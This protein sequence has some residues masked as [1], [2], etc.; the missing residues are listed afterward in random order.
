M[1]YHLGYRETIPD[2]TAVEK[3]T[4]FTLN[5]GGSQSTLQDIKVTE[6]SGGYSFKDQSKYYTRNRFI[7]WRIYHDVLELVE[8]SLDVNLIGNRIRY[9]FANTTVLDGVTIHEVFNSV[10]VLV[11]TASSVHRLSFP[12]PDTIHNQ[13][14]LFPRLG[15]EYSAKSIFAEATSND[16][17]NPASFYVINNTTAVADMPLPCTSATGFSSSQQQFFFALSYN[18]GIILLVKLDAITGSS[19][20]VE[21]KQHGDALIMPRFISRAFRG[22]NNKEEVTVS[23]IFQ[24]IASETYLFCLCQD[25][26]VR[27]WS[28]SR[29]HCSIVTDFSRDGN[30]GTQDHMI[31]KAE[32]PDSNNFLIATLLS[33]ST[34]STIQLLK[35]C[36]ENGSFTLKLALS[37]YTP[38]DEDVIDFAVTYSED[39]WA[40]FR[41]PHGETSVSQYKNGEWVSCILENPLDAMEIPIDDEVEAKQNYIDFI[42]HPG[43]FPVTVINK[44]LSIYRKSNIITDTGL[45]IHV[46]KERVCAVIDAQVN[47]ELEDRDFSEEGVVEIVNNCWQKFYSCCV[48]YYESGTRPIGLLLLAHQIPQRN[49]RFNVTDMDLDQEN[50]T[51]SNE[52]TESS[53]VDHI[54]ITTSG[55][56]IIKKLYVSLIRPTD[57]LEAVALNPSL[58]QEDLESEVEMLGGAT[59]KNLFK[60]IK[61]LIYLDDNLPYSMKLNFDKNLRNLKSPIT[62][63]GEF[64]GSG[65]GMGE[66]DTLSNLDIIYNVALNVDKIQDVEGLMTTLLDLLDIGQPDLP[67]GYDK[68]EKTKWLIHLGHLYGSHFATSFITNSLQQIVSVRYELCRCLLI[69]Q[70]LLTHGT[71]EQFIDLHKPVGHLGKGISERTSMLTQCYFIL[72]WIFQ[73]PVHKPQ[74]LDSI[75]DDNSFII[76]QERNSTTSDL[77]LASQSAALY[78]HFL[79]ACVSFSKVKVSFYFQLRNIFTYKSTPGCLADGVIPI[80]T[81]V[82]KFLLGCSL[83]DTGEHYK[84]FDVFN[85][86]GHGVGV[87]NFIK[88]KV[89]QM[90]EPLSRERLTVLYYLKIIKLFEQHNLYDLVIDLANHAIAISEKDDP[91]LPTLYSIIFLNRLHLRQYNAAYESLIS[92]PDGDRKKDCLRQLVVSL[93]N[94]RLLDTLL[95]FSFSGMQDDLERIIEGRARSLDVLNNDYYNFLYSFHTL[96]GTMRKAA[97]VMYEQAFRLSFDS[98]DTSIKTLEKQ[99]KCYIAAIN[100]LNLVKEEDAWIVKPCLNEEMDVMDTGSENNL[101]HL[102][103]Q[104]EVLEVGDIQKEYALCKA[105][106]RLLKFSPEHLNKMSSLLSAHEVSGILTNVG[107]YKDA[108]EICKLFNISPETTLSGL[109]SSC[110][111]LDETQDNSAWE[112]LTEND[113]SELGDGTAANLAWKLLEFFLRKYEASDSTSLHRAITHKLLQLG[114]FLPHW[115]V[116]SY[117]LKNPSELL[118]LLLDNGRLEEAAQ[119]AIEYAKAILGQGK[120]RFNLKSSLLAQNP[121]TWLPLN[122]FDLILLELEIHEKDDVE[123]KELREELSRVLDKYY[124]TAAAVSQDKIRLLG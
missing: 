98:T 66:E 50:D 100:S 21:L 88:E 122:A 60:L 59:I 9:R 79:S 68:I 14:H 6:R 48:E 102:R 116:A 7:Y 115:L 12:H 84:A 46:L 27:L 26:N 110:V 103:K 87:D 52:S 1:E 62:A 17:K 63:V 69:F 43:R 77:S 78:Q 8:Q 81:P 113:I 40:V 10:V 45:P 93:F 104:V 57:I 29:K 111:R 95:N 2:Q 86:A 117:K 96:R 112:W 16:A 28:T 58:T 47:S 25:G 11:A 73:T 124:K 37:I 30:Q 41:S 119:L 51:D 49:A 4:E 39:I 70:N 56:V 89:I 120:D 42:F 35:P 61:I 109:A 92:N 13:E 15:I 74:S 32:G 31:R 18:T 83:L 106:L 123:Y 72:M 23:M 20:S 97:C 67:E 71:F 55:V 94:S 99:C 118:R 85:R 34:Y 33:F 19:T 107:F 53:H 90:N 5:T 105:R 64:F 36:I 65:T 82:S 22:K 101:K 108:L 44:A 80:V 54:D 24:E 75:I 91:E 121:P 3:W 114:V 76:V 38:K